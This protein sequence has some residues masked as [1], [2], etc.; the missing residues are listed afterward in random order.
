MA[1]ELLVCSRRSVLRE[2][3]EKDSTEIFYKRTVKVGL[4]KCATITDNL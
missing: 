4:V 3:R 2:E 1:K